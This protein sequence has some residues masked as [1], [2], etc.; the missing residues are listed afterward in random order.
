LR[1]EVVN[2]LI[3]GHETTANALTWTW[4][5]LL[6]YPE[7]FKKVREEVD[8]VVA[9]DAPEFAELSKL[10]YTKAV[11]EESMRLFPPF[12]RISRRNIHDTTVGG[13]DLPAGT[14]VVTSIYTVQRKESHWTSPMEFR[15][16]RFLSP[17][18]KENKF[19]FIPFG[20]G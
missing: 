4:H 8:A 6:K 14:N 11:L 16:E 3:A 1:D 10:V 15:P 5:Q 18:K 20:A 9:G 12:W 19:A 7:V 2:M 13:Y 17:I